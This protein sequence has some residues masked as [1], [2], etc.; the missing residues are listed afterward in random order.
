MNTSTVDHIADRG[1]AAEPCYVTDL[2]RCEPAAALAAA[3][4]PGHWRTIDYETEGFGGAMLVAG[5]ETQAPAVRYPLDVRGWHAISVGVHATGHAGGLGQVLVRLSG[6]R[7]FSIL[8]WDPPRLHDG[9]FRRQ[10]LEELFWKA[11][12][13][14]GQQVVIAQAAV[15][16]GAGERPGAVQCEAAKLAYLKL[17]P[18]SDSEVEAL[19][20][21]RQRG[22]TRRLF[23]QNDAFFPFAYRTST[24]EEIRREI[25]PY[26]DT[27]FSR[28]YWEAGSGDLLWY[29]SEVARTPADIA[30]RDFS[31]T[32]ERL[33]VESWRLL[34]EQGLDPFQ[35]ALDYVHEIGLEFHASYRLAGW[36]YPPTVMEGFFGGGFYDRHPE[37]RCVDRNGRPLPR[38]SYAYPE[39]QR[40]CLSVLREIAGYPVD[41][42]CLLFNRRPPYLDHEPPLIEGFMARYGQDPRELDES[43]PR[44]LAYRA[45]VLT[46]FMR[47]VRRELDA[48]A[49]GQGRGRRIG[50][51]VC[52]LGTEQD[53]LFFG[54]DL[55]TW[56]REGLIDTLIPYSPAPLCLPV[57]SDT[58]SDPTQVAPFVKLTRGTDCT[59]AINLMPRELSA[60]DYRRMAAMLYGAGVDHL[61]VWDCAGAWFRANHRAPWTALRRLGHRNEIEA[62]RR[63]GEPGLA[64][65]TVPL[66]T[67]GGWDMT[68]IAPG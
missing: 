63:A 54:L 55:E 23:A 5:P 33:L 48:V 35:I 50:I 25:E 30:T 3:P 39:T 66:R 61:F 41:G 64:S 62:W 53:N 32:G 4:L 13:L 36:T 31:R 57:A 56:V 27:D 49:E 22:E 38:L 59:L 18:L 14:T 7:A 8:S 65:P 52:V 26:R 12:D 16:V 21:E 46:D 42:V 44:W 6:D 15:R 11:A 20:A 24:A 45:D 29:P 68:A 40:F 47:A 37:L 9:H 2:D 19:Q 34:R 17:V 43:D 1:F 51:S 28:I 67:L 10:Q 60:E 58:W